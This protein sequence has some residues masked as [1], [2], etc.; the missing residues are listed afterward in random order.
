MD[1]GEM[2]DWDQAYSNVRHVV[3]SDGYPPRWLAQSQ[4]FCRMFTAA[5]GKMRTISYGPDVRNR[6]DLVLPHR[7]LRGLM[8][9]VHGGYW[10]R[11]DRSHSTFLAAGA[12]AHGFAVALP[13]YTLCPQA[14]IATITQQI[15]AAIECAASHIDGPIHL[16]GHSAGGQ[17]VARMVTTT[18]PLTA[19]TQSRIRKIVPISCL[20][21]LRP[22]LRTQMNDV[23]HLDLD[24]AYRE[25][26]ALLEPLPGIDMT[27]W[28]GA[29]ELPEFVRQNA[30]LANVWSGFD[31]QVACI[32]ELDKHHLNIIDG[33]G[34]PDHLLTREV[35]CMT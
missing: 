18:S 10:Q 30:L 20:S 24:E 11:L 23:L 5:G 32:E 27:A 19:K 12:L 31:C 15:G 7:P 17:L 6:L 13:S 16:T 14:R 1:Q 26:P 34:D 29:A 22:L 28:V 8:I 4:E 21:D 35:L 3:G 25:S 9:Y 33:L 2:V